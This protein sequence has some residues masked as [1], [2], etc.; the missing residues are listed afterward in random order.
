MDGDRQRFDKHQY[1]S[2][3]L[4]TRTAHLKVGGEVEAELREADSMM[5][6]RA[7]GEGMDGRGSGSVGPDCRCTSVEHATSMID[8]G[9]GRR[10]QW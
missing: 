10:L 1:C 9:V 6:V 3:T 2:E 4:R 8:R 5:D 7:A